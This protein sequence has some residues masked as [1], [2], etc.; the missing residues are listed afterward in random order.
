MGHCSD[1]VFHSLAGDCRL[2]TP[3][4]VVD[5]EVDI[6]SKAIV[7]GFLGWRRCVSFNGSFL[8]ADLPCHYIRLAAQPHSFTGGYSKGTHDGITLVEGA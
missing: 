5:C 6:P 2:S 3:P 4:C 7:L 1:G 8:C